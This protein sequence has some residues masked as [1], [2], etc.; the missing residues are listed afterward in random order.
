MYTGFAAALAAFL[1]LTAHASA[2]DGQNCLQVPDAAKRLA[3]F[4]AAASSRGD[5]QLASPTGESGRA[6]QE[7]APDQATSQSRWRV[8]VQRDLMGGADRSFVVQT[9]LQFN[10]PADRNPQLTLRCGIEG[11][12]L[13]VVYNPSIYLGRPSRSSDSDSIKV[14]LRF[15]AGDP[16]EESWPPST[17]RAAAFARDARLFY[18][19][20]LRHKTVVVESEAHSTRQKV[21]GEFSTAGLAEAASAL[22]GCLPPLSTPEITREHGIAADLIDYVPSWH[23]LPRGREGQL[24]SQQM[25]AFYGSIETDTGNQAALMFWCDAT[26]LVG[27]MQFDTELPSRVT[28]LYMISPGAGIKYA[29]PKKIGVRTLSLPNPRAIVKVFES[30]AG[31][32]MATAGGHEKSQFF[33]VFGRAMSSEQAQILSSCINPPASRQGKQPVR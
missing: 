16:K 1:A 15:D 11:N 13:E 30:G 28:E 24:A 9:A 14:R 20:L 10:G 17:N 12:T 8:E 22:Q 2:Q 5:A 3:C 7:L 6:P 33:G 21:A 31:G 26:N 27:V 19:R 32:V 4:E 25:V 23:I 29:N 18:E